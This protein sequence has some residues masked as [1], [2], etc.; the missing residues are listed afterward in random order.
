MATGI[1]ESMLGCSWTHL[2]KENHV[3]DAFGSSEHHHEPID[4]NADAT[5]R[6]HAVF[7]S[8]EEILVELLSFSPALMFES[9]ALEVGIVEFRVA[10]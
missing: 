5:R 8:G 9:L 2:R 3:T 4:T 7:E 6:R 10:W 1:S